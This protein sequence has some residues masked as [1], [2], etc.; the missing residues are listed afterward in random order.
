V[1]IIRL[2]YTICMTVT[3]NV[4][5]IWINHCVLWVCGKMNLV[6]QQMYLKTARVTKVFSSC[7]QYLP[8]VRSKVQPDTWILLCSCAIHH[9]ARFGQRFHFETSIRTIFSEHWCIYRTRS[10]L[11]CRNGQATVHGDPF[12]LIPLPII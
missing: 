5:I 12:V 3:I 4:R 10:K 6:F 7:L 11:L 8:V 9:H 1:T 2:Y